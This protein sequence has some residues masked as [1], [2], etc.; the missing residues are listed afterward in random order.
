MQSKE[1]IRIIAQELRRK[2]KGGVFEHSVVRTLYSTDASVFRLMPT[3]VVEPKDEEDI[4]HVLTFANKYKLPVAARGA[5]TGLAGESLTTGIVLDFSVHM[6]NIV[7]IDSRANRVR[8]QPGVIPGFLNKKLAETGKLFGPNP[9]TSNYCTIGGMIG[10]NSTGS[11]SLRYGMT[12]KWVKS[13]KVML[14]DGQVCKL[15]Q[16]D[17]TSSEFREILDRNTR[18]SEIYKSIIPLLRQNNT[19][20]NET[21]PNTPRN[22]HGYLLKDVVV[23]DQI[24]LCKLYCASEGTLGILLEA[25]LEVCDRPK[26]TKLVNFLFSDRYSAAKAAAP[27]LQFDPCAVEIIDNVCLDMARQSPNYSTLFGPEID[28]LLMVEFDGDTIEEIEERLQKATN[29]LIDETKLAIGIQKYN[30]KEEENRIW[31]MRKLIAGMINRFPGEFQPVPIIEDI[32]VRPEILPNLLTGIADILKKKELEHLCYGHAGAGT[33]HLRPFI[34]RTDPETYK[35]MPEVCDEVYDLTLK[36][37]GTISGE[38]GDGFLRAPF[39]KKQY[40]ELFET[41]KKIKLIFDPKNILNPNKKTGCTDFKNWTENI[42]FPDKYPDEAIT[43]LM[44]WDNTLHAAVDACNGCGACRN[45]LLDTDMCPINRVFGKEASTPRAKANLMRSILMGEMKGVEISELLEVA[46][47]CIHCK[48]CHVDCPSNVRASDMMLELKAQITR[49]MG[50][51]FDTA[52]LTNMESFL[53][54]AALFPGMANFFSG[55]PIT[56]ELVDLFIGLPKER[57]PPLLAQEKFSTRFKGKSSKTSGQRVVYFF[58]MF[59]DLVTTNI[60]HSLLKVLEHHDI[61]VVVPEQKSSGVVQICYGDVDK[62]RNIANYNVSRLFPYAKEGIKI[63]CTEPTAA[64]MIKEE[65]LML[66]RS[67]EFQQVS[68]ATIDITSFLLELVKSNQLKTDFKPLAYTLG[69]HTPCHLKKLGGDISSTKLLS[70]IPELKVIDIDEGCCGI[71]G[72]FGMRK[73]GF[74]TSLEIGKGLFSALSHP[75]IDFGLT[76]CSTCRI[77]MNH[78]VPD[79]KVFHPIE[80]LA[81]AYGPE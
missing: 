6:N 10:N 4:G 37:K 58:D 61:E 39:I 38:H 46:S 22:R 77:Q 11:H 60:G 31:S 72:T 64:L 56:R 8:V 52:A 43:E 79:K 25:E 28:S 70:S 14:E 15:E 59:A 13:L 54:F 20:I 47:Y 33:V 41:F 21:W 49:K 71:A 51:S 42:R 40:G 74:K 29:H 78:G 5:G 65:Y 16:K 57:I 68:E 3:L 81:M 2:Q 27:L 24:D 17:I 30:S 9:S 69:H 76:E 1:E 7:E 44:S 75:Q 50:K 45:K 18:E 35:W 55:L 34:K 32:C 63:I 19:L 66:D 36:L 53:R 62:A 73:K 80:I 23:D 67:K 48:M 26:Q 12:T